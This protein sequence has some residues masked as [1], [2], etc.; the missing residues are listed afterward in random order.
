M[1]SDNPKIPSNSAAAG[2]PTPDITQENLYGKEAKTHDN[3]DDLGKVKYV[4]PAYIL[5][6]KG[7]VEKEKFYLPRSYVVLFDGRVIY[8]RTSKAQAEK[9]FK[10]EF[11]PT[12]EEYEK[13]YPTTGEK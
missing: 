7:L 3:G 2:A 10:R 12:P 13:S 11:P 1:H 8:F 5:T 6:V 9:E 4:G